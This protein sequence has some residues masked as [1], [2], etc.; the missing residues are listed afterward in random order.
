MSWPPEGACAPTPCTSSDTA[1]LPAFSKGQAE[2]NTGGHS[3]PCDA[4][5]V[6]YHPSLGGNRAKDRQ[7]RPGRPMRSR[8]ISREKS[9]SAEDQ[10]PSTDRGDK[11]GAAPRSFRNADRR[12]VLHGS[13]RARLPPGTQMMSRSGGHSSNERRAETCRPV[14]LFTTSGS[15]RPHVSSLPSGWSACS[16][17]RP[18]RAR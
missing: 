2:V 16:A 15:S 18:C 1:T 5:T 10:R 7:Q 6:A 4:I 9:C 12:I 13:Q 14:S 11:L 17:G 3:T 8:S